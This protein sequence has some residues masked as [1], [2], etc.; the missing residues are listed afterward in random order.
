MARMNVRI[1]LGR[2]AGSNIRDRDNRAIS[3][4]RRI[5]G[6]HAVTRGSRRCSRPNARTRRSLGVCARNRDSVLNR[7]TRARVVAVPR[8]DDE[9]RRASRVTTCRATK[10]SA[11]GLVENDSVRSRV[12]EG[13]RER[14]ERLSD[15]KTGVR[16]KA[17]YGVYVVREGV[18]RHIRRENVRRL[19]DVREVRA[20]RLK[21]K[22]DRPDSGCRIRH[23]SV[24]CPSSHCLQVE[25]HKRSGLQEWD[26]VQMLY[27]SRVIV[28][29]SAET[30]V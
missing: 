14:F 16:I 7:A 22:L 2:Q 18:A 30:G 1:T 21:E 29:T 24:G 6:V 20:V 5:V 19:R 23:E 17:V 8:R 12:C 26:V 27:P 28:K 25:R 9:R 3:Q 4:G 11:T 13:L 10:E 15:R